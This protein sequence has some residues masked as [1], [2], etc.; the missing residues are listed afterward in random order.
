MNRYL[1]SAAIAALSVSA[2]PAVACIEL[3]GAADCS[4]SF[5]FSSATDNLVATVPLAGSVLHTATPPDHALEF[6]GVDVTLDNDGSVVGLVD[7]GVDAGDGLTVRN[8]SATNDVAGISGLGDG[9][10]AGDDFTLDNWG[11]ISSALDDAVQGDDRM[12]IVNRATGVI[13]TDSVSGDNAI[14]AGDDLNLTNRGEILA[15]NAGEGVTAE[16]RAT[17]DNRAGATI[18]AAGNDAVQVQRG[19]DITNRG[20]IR[21][22][23]DDGVDIDDGTIQNLGAYDTGTDTGTIIRST[24]SSGIDFDGQAPGTDADD[25][26]G[27]ALILNEGLIEGLA[28]IT[29]ETVTDAPN[30]QYANTSVQTVLNY[31]TVRGTAGPAMVLGAG[32]DEVVLFDQSIVDGLVLLGTGDDLLYFGSASYSED[33]FESVFDGEDDTDEARFAF[34]L[35]ELLGIDELGDSTVL[36]SFASFDV[37]LRNFEFAS[38]VTGPA[39]FETIAL[40]SGNMDAVPLPASVALL[41]GGLV[42]LGAARR[43]R[44]KG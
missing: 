31:G 40:P 18:V 43:R 2:V 38:F 41:G 27:D 36:L 34:A 15:G 28:G 19:A 8:G 11:T 22:D 29:V 24:A 13:F 16:D 3:G 4:S 23:G 10:N 5:G 14:G 12:E 1:V 20:L 39:T 7:R 6:T 33:G 21:S 35:A 32:N 25:G 9:I 42:A 26:V 37:L 44:R 17:I 30:G